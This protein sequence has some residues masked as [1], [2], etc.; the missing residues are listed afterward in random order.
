M[1]ELFLSHASVIYSG[2]LQLFAWLAAVIDSA[3]LDRRQAL[4]ATRPMDVRRTPSQE[5]MQL[6]CGLH[7]LMFLQCWLQFVWGNAD[8]GVDCDCASSA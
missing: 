7:T 3:V 4:E 8:R 5:V 6:G 1:L 2:I